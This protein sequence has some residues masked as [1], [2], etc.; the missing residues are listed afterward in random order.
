MSIV[1]AWHSACQHKPGDETSQLFWGHEAD[2]RLRPGR[3]LCGGND[4]KQKV[5]GVASV[6][7]DRVVGR[8]LDHGVPIGDV[9]H[10]GVLTGNPDPQAVACL[11]VPEDGPNLYVVLVDLVRLDERGVS[12]R[13][14]GLRRCG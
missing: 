4:R 14:I 10:S 8:L 12:V 7:M 11:E 6:V 9:P 2:L 5:R 3:S 13:M 1:P